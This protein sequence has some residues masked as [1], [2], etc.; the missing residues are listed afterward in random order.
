MLIW[1]I[2]VENGEFLQVF[3]HVHYFR[4]QHHQI[5]HTRLTRGSLTIKTEVCV[6]FS[7]SCH[8][9]LMCGGVVLSHEILQIKGQKQALHGGLP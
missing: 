1:C 8:V 3:H 4:H 6:I 2:G 9:Y 5:V 7:G